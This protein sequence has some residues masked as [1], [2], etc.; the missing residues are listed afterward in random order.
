M[1]VKKILSILFSLLLCATIFSG[2]SSNFSRD[3]QNEVNAAFAEAVE[4]LKN[5][6]HEHGSSLIET[7]D[8]SMFSLDFQE[9]YGNTVSS[10]KYDFELNF[11]VRKNGIGNVIDARLAESITTITAT[12][13]SGNILTIKSYVPDDGYAYTDAGSYKS[14]SKHSTD[15]TIDNLFPYL[16]TEY[17]EEVSLETNGEQKIFHFKVLSSYS[18]LLT[19]FLMLDD[20]IRKTGD[21]EVVDFSGTLVT[22]G[23]DKISLTNNVEYKNKDTNEVLKLT[24][25][26]VQDNSS[27]ELEFP[28]DFDSYASTGK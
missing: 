19:N 6:T 21:I 18:R 25:S 15:F 26:S 7:S 8:S 22:D 13:T 28:N 23:S 12:H 27:H 20:N 4:K 9:H 17:L 16:N 1:S 10:I 3:K 24:Q 5:T 11:D 14:K 2:C